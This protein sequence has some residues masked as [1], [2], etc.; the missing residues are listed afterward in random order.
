MREYLEK[1]VGLAAKQIELVQGLARRILH[2]LKQRGEGDRDAGNED[3]RAAKY[4]AIEARI[5]A[6]VDAGKISEED[7]ERKLEAVKDRMF[8]DK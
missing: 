4:R 8:G 3:K 6:A 1:G 5:K 7:A 2:G